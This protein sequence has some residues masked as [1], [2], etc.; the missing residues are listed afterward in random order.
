MFFKGLNSTSKRLLIGCTG[1]GIAIGVIFPFYA[2]FFTDYKFAMEFFFRLGCI[3][4]GIL[5]GMI[6][7]FL[8]RL[9]VYRQI[10]RVAKRLEDISSG[11]G[12]LTKRI[13]ISSKDELGELSH[14]FNAFVNRLSEIIKNLIHFNQVKG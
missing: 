7:Y 12:D 14:W 11:E 13:F 4:A 3:S 5:I 6:N 8:V 10:D 2:R 9:I 1:F